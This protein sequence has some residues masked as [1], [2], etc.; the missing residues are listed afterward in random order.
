MRASD[1]DRELCSQVLKD[2]YAAGRLDSTGFYER[3]SAVWTARTQG[4]L[5]ALVDDLIAL[6]PLPG[7]PTPKQARKARNTVATIFFV[8]SMV[9]SLG[10][11]LLAIAVGQWAE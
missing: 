4:D 7:A 3:S 10:G 6:P 9:L 1:A 8:L 5:T 11:I 2:A